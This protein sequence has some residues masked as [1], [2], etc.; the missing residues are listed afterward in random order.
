MSTC[1]RRPQTLAVCPL[2]HLAVKCSVGSSC[3]ISSSI[4]FSCSHVYFCSRDVKRLLRSFWLTICCW[5]F[6]P[7]ILKRVNTSM[8]VFQSSRERNRGNAS[9]QNIQPH[10]TF[11]TFIKDLACCPAPHICPKCLFSHL[12]T[13]FSWY[14]KGH[15]S[16]LHDCPSLSATFFFCPDHY[17]PCF[18]SSSS[19]ASDLDTAAQT[20]TFI[21]GTMVDDCLDYLIEWSWIH[22]VCL[23]ETRAFLLIMSPSSLPASLQACRVWASIVL[24]L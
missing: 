3:F 6:H 23:S 12:L 1:P 22:L 8:S 5:W 9:G 17:T 11:L 14:F 24:W 13:F 2:G 18:D 15:M 16:L 20:Q 21:T 7:V 10:D 19:L 4:S